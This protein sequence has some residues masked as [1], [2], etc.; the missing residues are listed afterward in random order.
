M[1]RISKYLTY[2]TYNDFHHEIVVNEH[3]IE[4]DEEIWLYIK[5]YMRLKHSIY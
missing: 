2:R 3:N 4:S 5:T 1:E